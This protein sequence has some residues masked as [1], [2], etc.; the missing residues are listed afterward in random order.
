[1]RSIRIFAKNMGD[2]YYEPTIVV[3]DICTYRYTS[4]IFCMRTPTHTCCSSIGSRAGS[5]SSAT[6]SNK[7]GLPKRT[8]F[9]RLLRKSLSVNF[10][11]SILWSFSYRK[12][13]TYTHTVCTHTSLQTQTL[14]FYTNRYSLPF[15][16]N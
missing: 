7:H 2:P 11:T 3:H 8:Q 1:M 16:T 10:N 15:S 14:V 5:S 12:E 6:F 9:S 13:L 4:S